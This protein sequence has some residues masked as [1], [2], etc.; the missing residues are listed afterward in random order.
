MVDT[1]EQTFKEYAIEEFLVRNEPYYRSVG[2]ELETIYRGIPSAH[3]RIAQG[4]HRL[5]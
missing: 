2:D 5:R 3:P 1:S 4:A